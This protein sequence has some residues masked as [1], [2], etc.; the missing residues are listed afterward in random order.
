MKKRAYT[1]E[2][3]RAQTS[4]PPPPIQ[5]IKNEA[6]AA[7]EKTTNECKPKRERQLCSR[8]AKAGERHER[9]RKRTITIARRNTRRGS[10]GSECGGKT[11]NK[12]ERRAI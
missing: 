12:E 10:E 1:P 6:G 8:V 7:E 5:L 2:G 11:E 9:E 3:G 4:E